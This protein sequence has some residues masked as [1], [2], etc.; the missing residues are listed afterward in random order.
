MTNQIMVV[1]LPSE[2]LRLGKDVPPRSAIAPFFPPDLNDLNK[3][4]Y[5]PPQESSAEDVRFNPFRYSRG[6]C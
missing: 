6:C 3:L 5:V 2:Q 1:L 4:P